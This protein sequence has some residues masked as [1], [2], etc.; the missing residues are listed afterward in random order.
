MSHIQDWKGAMQLTERGPT[1]GW[2]L[3]LIESIPTLLCNL[4]TYIKMVLCPE[5][6]YRLPKSTLQ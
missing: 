1:L 3:I 6:H 2:L 5:A 4:D